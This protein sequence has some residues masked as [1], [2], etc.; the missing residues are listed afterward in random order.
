MK[1]LIF[2]IQK[3][4]LHDGAGIRTSVFFQGCNMR[5]KWCSNPEALEMR[6]KP[7]NDGAKYYTVDGIMAELVKDKPF[8]DASGGG[9]TLTGGEPLLQSEFIRELCDALRAS[10]IGI[11]AETSANVA[12]DVFKS[13]SRKFDTIIIDMKHYDSEAHRRGTGTGNEQI[14]SN[15]ASALESDLHT[16]IRI[17]VIPGFN[18]SEEDIRGFAELL[19]RIG[20]RDVQLLPFHQFGESKYRKLGLKY[21]YMGAAQLHEEHLA[22]FARVLGG[23][24]ENVQ[25]GG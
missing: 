19:K 16:I 8:Y 2:N 4:S 22:P 25:I 18:D 6:P 3:F 15:I 11:A 17:P 10:E 7:E 20:A 9:V 21:E 24:V 13:V 12:E 1:G 23:I 14:M 5:C